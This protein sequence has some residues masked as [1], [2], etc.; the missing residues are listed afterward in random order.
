M[1]I[2]GVNW[3]HPSGATLLEDGIVVASVSEERFSRV[4]NDVVFP[5]NAIRWCLTCGN[6]PGRVDHAAIASHRLPYY[7][8]LYHQTNL[9]I[10]NMIREQR[11]VWF[12]RIYSGKKIDEAM[13][14]EDLWVHDQYPQ[15]YWTAYD[16]RKNES[17][18]NDRLDILA[19][20][21]EMD[22]KNIS[23][24]EHHWCHA[25]Y[26]LCASPYRHEDVA[27]VTIDGFGDGLNA[28]VAITEPDGSLRRIYQ[29]DKCIVGRI[30]SHVT[31]L[32]GMKR[33]EHEFKV[34]GLAPYAKKQYAKKAYDIFADV[35]DLDGIDF[36]WKNR[37]TDAYF[38]FKE[39]LEG[40]RFDNIAAGL[41][42]WTED[43]L[44]RWVE[45]IV[46]ETGRDT[47]VIS[48]GV[49][50]NVKAMGAIAALPCVKRMYVAGSSSDD[51]VCIGAAIGAAMECSCRKPA[52]F[53]VSNLYLG[54]DIKDEDKRVIVD[55]AHA[56]DEFVV[57]EGVTTE[58]VADLLARGFVVGRCCGRMEFGQRALGNRSIL[59]DPTV[60]G[61]VSRIN[62]MI[63]Q[64]D[65]WMPFAP[66]VLDTYASEYLC[67]PKHIPSPHMTIGYETTP[68][69]YKAMQAACHPA[70]RSAR[71]QILRREDNPELYELLEKFAVRTDRGALL[72]TSFNLHGYPIVNTPLEAYE[73]FCESDLDAL[74][75]DDCL[76]CRKRC[77]ASDHRCDGQATK[78][79]YDEEADGQAG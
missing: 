68:A 49:S 61:L 57:E 39:R 71:A 50:M 43:I 11:E 27:V 31:L 51:S 25:Y 48:G 12:P 7:V 32:L 56:D 22:R 75:I 9:S 63:K 65:F 59:A 33:L 52:A 34:M 55:R 36:V 15:N 21:L 3:A 35:L 24:V 13:V 4:K 18:S 47:I 79:G 53:A 17:F 46:K 74:F 58:D 29:T 28:T 10:E 69:G 64:R 1:R 23:A 20:F 67:N 14:F 42:L 37:P 16:P 54:P 66:V 76:V 78:R 26:G 2:L 40:I 8:M 30:Y 62:A 6:E 38:Y 77:S 45:N 72:N 73:V 60:P 44:C 19:R 70:D 5:Q 41:Q